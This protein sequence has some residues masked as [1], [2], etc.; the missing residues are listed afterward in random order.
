MTE[1]EIRETIFLV[2]GQIAPEADPSALLPDENMREA[3]DIDSYDFRGR[4]TV[5]AAPPSSPCA[6][7]ST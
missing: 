2:L 3:L 7:A 4:V 1:P 6:S 5:K